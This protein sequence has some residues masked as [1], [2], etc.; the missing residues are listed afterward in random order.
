MF[1][2]PLYQPTSVTAVLRRHR[3]RWRSDKTHWEPSLK[4]PREGFCFWHPPFATAVV[5]TKP[6][7][8]SDKKGSSSSEAA[9]KDVFVSVE[10]VDAKGKKKVLAKAR[11][12]LME[13]YDHGKQDEGSTP[14]KKAAKL[15]LYPETKKVAKA[16]ANL[17]IQLLR[18]EEAVEA[19][20]A[21]ESAKGK[22]S[23]AA[24]PADSLSLAL[25]QGSIKEEN[26]EESPRRKPVEPSPIRLMPKQFTPRLAEEEEDR[27]TNEEE[28][29]SPPLSI[30]VIPPVASRKSSDP[31]S[32]PPKS[33]DPTNPVTSTPLATAP[34]PRET[35]SSSSSF[36]QPQTVV[37]AA[38]A[39]AAKDQSTSSS[40][41]NPASPPKETST[42]A[43]DKKS[44]SAS[45]KEIVEAV[46]NVVANKPLTKSVVEQSESAAISP[47][48]VSAK[49]PPVAEP[50]TPPKQTVP[51]GFSSATKAAADSPLCRT[52]GDLMRLSG[53][54]GTRGSLRGDPESEEVLKWAKSLLRPYPQV[55]ITNLHSSW[56]N[57]VG[58]C[59]LLHSRYPELIP[60]ETLRPREVEAN[61]ALAA[62]ACQTVGVDI[63]NLLQGLQ[64]NSKTTVRF[65]AELRRVFEDRDRAPLTPE[66]V[67]SF[68]ARAW[69]RSRSEDDSSVASSLPALSEKSV[70]EEEEQQRNGTENLEDS[71]NSEPAPKS[72]KDIK[73]E[74][75]EENGEAETP[76]H[77]ISAN[78]KRALNLIAEAQ[79]SESV[80]E[81]SV[82]SATESYSSTATAGA[83]TAATGGGGGAGINKRESRGD[84]GQITNELKLLELDTER[85]AHEQEML[86][87]ILREGGGDTDAGVLPRY[88]QL[89]NEKNGLVRRQMQLNLFEKEAELGARQAEIR[90]KLQALSA[91]ED[92]KKTEAVKEEEARLLEELVEVVNEQNELV[93]HLDSQ[94]RGISEDQSIEASLVAPA[95]ATDGKKPEECTIQ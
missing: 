40:V 17:T 12:D 62:Q 53:R 7:E 43:S 32:P 34:K 79:R 64:I 5:V 30:P 45:P 69:A 87:K 63:P 65:L 3:R 52:P 20:A 72:S 95:A 29:R 21:A 54:G 73:E 1:P 58:F 47:E 56:Q 50:S 37:S 11:L 77:S 25:S 89:V 18:G 74:T 35:A 24:T 92:E 81:D 42:S 33:S 86:E 48:S 9:H 93:H 36:S 16:H 13:Y 38:A 85:L 67:E 70:E 76:T 6:K 66:Q 51:I 71:A 49:S 4:S 83:S 39:A 46:P 2:S 55:K 91:T 90:S 61:F 75:K 27:P 88:L 59:A 80:G 60:L 94:E 31:S 22:E 28:E 23:L 44:E 19:A 82:S 78:R 57:G 15:K 41:L 68:R 10:N 26:E 14:A 84:L 8:K